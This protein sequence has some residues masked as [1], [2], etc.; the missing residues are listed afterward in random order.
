MW[1]LDN[2]ITKKQQ[3]KL[4]SC[5]SCLLF[6]ILTPLNLFMKTKLMVNSIIQVH[7]RQPW[8]ETKP[9]FSLYPPLKQK[10]QG[11][12]AAVKSGFSVQSF[13]LVIVF[14][15]AKKYWFYTNSNIRVMI[16]YSEI[17]LYYGDS[18]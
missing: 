5:L 18:V 9:S 2:K 6:F 15:S 8:M 17:L 14:H 4:V 11:T 1:T 7:R 10:P 3:K 13:E 16:A 12:E